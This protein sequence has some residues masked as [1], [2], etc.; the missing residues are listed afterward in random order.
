MAVKPSGTQSVPPGYQRF[1]NLKINTENNSNFGGS[2]YPGNGTIFEGVANTTMSKTTSYSATSVTSITIAGGTDATN[3][4]LIAWL[5]N[6]AE[7]QEKSEP[8]PEPI[9]DLTGTK[10]VFNETLDNTSTSVMHITFNSNGNTYNT[11]FRTYE[12]RLED[13]LFYDDISPYVSGTWEEYNYRIIEI[14]G[15]SD[16]TNANLIA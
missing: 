4:E 6:N 10:W 9:T 7:L 1:Y 12:P 8:E 11:I 16:V 15:G 5:M 13:D 2:I 3:P 14:T